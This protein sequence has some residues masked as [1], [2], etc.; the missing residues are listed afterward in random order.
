MNNDSGVDVFPDAENGADAGSDAGSE[1]L[2]QTDD[3]GFDGREAE[4]EADMEPD[5][6]VENQPDRWS[7]PESLLMLDD[8]RCDGSSGVEYRIELEADV[9]VV[10]AAAAAA[11]VEYGTDTRPLSVRNA[12]SSLQVV[13][14]KNVFAVDLGT[15]VQ[16]FG[17]DVAR[18]LVLPLRPQ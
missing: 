5:G 12:K 16:R 4:A 8:P 3:L 10:I 17:D 18:C 13:G 15:V 9:E 2:L 6:G 1:S 11:A 14:P 7:L